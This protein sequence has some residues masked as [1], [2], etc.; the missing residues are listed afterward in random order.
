M[1]IKELEAK[2]KE[3]KELQRM[4]DELTAEM[5]VIKDEI[6]IAL[7]DKEEVIA[8]AFKITNKPV[9]SNRMDTT[10]IKKEL[11]EIAQRYNKQSTVKR[12]V[13]V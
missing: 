3:L 11:P 8:G 13:I 5:D 9:T 1:S 10:A 12:L 7:G 2:A 4:A 6:R